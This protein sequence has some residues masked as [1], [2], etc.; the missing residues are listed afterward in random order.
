MLKVCGDSYLGEKSFHTEHCAELGVEQLESDGPIVNTDMLV[1]PLPEEEAR[2]VDLL[3]GPNHVDIPDFD[4]LPEA[5]ELPVLLKVGDDVS[6]D[7]I[8]PAGTRAMPLWSSVTGMSEY[9]FEGCDPNYPE[10]AR[11]VSDA[12]GHAVVGG[13]NY[14]QGSSREKA[15]LA[16]RYLGLRVVIAKR[17]ARI[18]WENLVNYGILPLTFADEADYDSIDQGDKLVLSGVP[19]ALR[20]GYRRLTI[21]NRG[22]GAELEVRHSLSERQVEVMLKGG[23]IKWMR[24][25][26]NDG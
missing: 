24:G 5:M 2:K 22:K 18:H 10:R 9:A 6:T 8:M 23:L 14:G 16:P 1:P 15:A 19:Q 13:R 17:Y 20:S 25:R 12:G 26:I 4:P 7:E 21:E 3:K 11:E